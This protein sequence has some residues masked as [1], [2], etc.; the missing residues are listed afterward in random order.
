MQ[1]FEIDVQK[2]AEAPPDAPAALAIGSG[3]IV[4]TRLL[5]QGANAPEDQL[6]APPAQLAFWL[7]D[8]WWRLRWEC[9]P[10]FG[11]TPEWRLAH[12]L[13]SMSGYAWPR[14]AIWGEGNRIGLSARSDPAG[15]VGPVRYLTDALIYISAAAFEREADRFLDVVSQETAGFAS[16]WQALRAQIDVLTAER[17]DP[18]ICDWRRLEAELG[19]DIDEA[20]EAL[21]NILQRFQKEYGTGAVTEAALAVQG[22]RSAAVLEE[23]IAV[24]NEHHW[25]CDL[26]RTAL[27]VDGLEKQ[28]D[29]PPWRLG[30]MAAA[31]L[32]AKVGYPTGP[33]R[34]R[35]LAD[36]LN[37]RPQ[38]LRGVQGVRELAY[39]L[40]LNTGRWRGEV[41]ALSSRWPADRRFEFTRALGDAI[42]SGNERLGPLT[43]AKSARQKF[44]RAF[45]QSLLCPYEALRDY[46]GD[47]TSDGALWAA[48]REFHVSDRLIRSLLVNKGDLRRYR[49]GDST[50]PPAA[51][52]YE[53]MHH[54]FDEVVEAA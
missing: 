46:I 38:A 25:Q 52:G 22:D 27:L 54:E 7:I 29:D 8:N 11:P 23:E 45:A 34:N 42:W 1:E 37:V 49:L 15:V 41:V 47:D 2:T 18:E 33:L 5:R 13:S 3:H 6:K 17:A 20:P 48:A 28:A 19:Y 16:D 50:A 35:V 36:I 53:A 40:R 26:R 12:D 39:G 24:A 31:E 14:L 9:V 4:L 32:R 10:P 44:Q 43:R 51:R 21:I 30:E